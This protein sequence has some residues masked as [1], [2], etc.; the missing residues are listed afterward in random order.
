MVVVVVV[1]YHFLFQ[2]ELLQYHRLLEALALGQVMEIPLK[3]S[4][5][6]NRLQPEV[7]N[8]LVY[9]FKASV[10]AVELVDQLLQPQVL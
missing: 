10:V 3:E 7:R 9:A 2:L 4:L 5:E 1:V 6:C 8:L